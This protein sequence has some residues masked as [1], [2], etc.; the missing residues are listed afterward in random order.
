M[1]RN[2][3]IK[4]SLSTIL[5][6]ISV[7]SFA[8]DSSSE[9][10]QLYSKRKII[11]EKPLD[12]DTAYEYGKMAAKMKKYNEAIF[13]Y[14]HMLSYSPDLHRVKLDL[15]IIYYK[16][17]QLEKA[18]KLFKEVKESN[19]PENVEK[20]ISAMI[21][22][23]DNDLK[24]HQITVAVTT[25]VNRDTNA[26]SAASSGRITFI[27]PISN[28]ETIIPLSNGSSSVKDLQVNASIAIKHSKKIE[29]DLIKEAKLRWNSSATHYLS[30]QSK[31]ETI[32]IE[33][34]NFKTGP[35]IELPSI[36]TTLSADFSH[37]YIRLDG[38]EYLRIN[39]LNGNANYQY[40]DKLAF[41]INTSLEDRNY[42]NSPTILTYS[43]KT[44]EA[45]QL[46]L[47]ATYK[48]TPRNILGGSMGFRKEYTR[49]DYN[50]NKQ[51]SLLGNYTRVF[52]NG[53]FAN[54]SFGFKNTEYDANDPLISILD[55][56]DQER[57]ASLLIGKPINNRTTLSIGYQF[58]NVGSN[59]Q[60]Y[61][62]HNH[63]ITSN[64]LYK[65]DL[66]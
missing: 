49:A 28:S 12:M 9:E 65:L 62:Y 47:G 37:N 38:N 31:L 4:L 19:P 6:I 29:Q 52:N 50:D 33:L 46:N 26:N 11:E 10:F 63:R 55:R 25:G 36:N 43:D 58:K 40:S 14:E 61:D 59:I 20:N 21:K 66:Y 44:G 17:N 41:N 42:V 16:T 18:H 48:L 2:L 56:K 64:I 23:I 34:Y 24:E 54:L 27:D 8:N 45:Y 3:Y 1:I 51:L 35:I 5:S 7:N 60:N 57:S 39:S 32:D 53:V 13:A 30:K 22:K 15:A